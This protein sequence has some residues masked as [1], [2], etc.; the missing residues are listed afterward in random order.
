MRFQKTSRRRE[1]TAPHLPMPFPA[2][3]PQVSHR[4]EAHFFIFHAERAA[5]VFATGAV[6][7][8]PGVELIAISAI[9]MHTIRSKPFIDIFTPPK[10]TKRTR[11]TQL[12]L[13]N[14]AAQSDIF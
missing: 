3:P 4:G 13:P 10:N 1:S 9:P 2:D 6:C 7:A 11:G 8:T 12:T 14:V 5:A